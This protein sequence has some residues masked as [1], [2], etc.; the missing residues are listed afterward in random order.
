MEPSLEAMV[1]ALAGP[2]SPPTAVVWQLAGGGRME[3][4][5]PRAAAG[6]GTVPH[7]RAGPEQVTVGAE[8]LS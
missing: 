5:R 3:L 1:R 6:N 4:V 7:W 8:K 2:A